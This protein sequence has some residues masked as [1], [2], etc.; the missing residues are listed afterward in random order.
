MVLVCRRVKRT[1]KTG[2]TS[3]GSWGTLPKIKELITQEFRYLIF[4]IPL[5]YKRVKRKF[6]CFW[7]TIKWWSKTKWGCLLLHLP[8]VPQSQLGFILC[9]ISSPDRLRVW[10]QEPCRSSLMDPSWPKGGTVTFRPSL[11]APR[12]D[13][14]VRLERNVKKKKKKKQEMST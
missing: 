3:D 8:L 11:V 6:K 2:K 7:L 12:S 13:L 14:N 10:F 9:L 1:F 5:K 4:T